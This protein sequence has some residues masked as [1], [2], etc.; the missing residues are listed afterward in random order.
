[1]EKEGNSIIEVSTL[2]KRFGNLTAVNQISFSVS[3]GE[4]FGFLGPNGAG[5]TTT[6]RTLTGLLT[7]DSG[8]IFVDGHDIKKNLIKAKMKMGVIPE[9]GNVYVDLT[10]KQN[11][12]LAG[13]FYGISTKELEKR[14]DYLLDEFGLYE[15]KDDIVKTFSKGMKQ[16]VNIASAI[17]HN[18]DILFLDEPTMGLDVQSQRL[19][20][21]I[22]KDMNQR[23]TTIFL[24]THNIEEANIQCQRVG[25][26]NKGTIAAID[27]PENL[28]RIFEQAQSVEISFNKPINIALIKNSQLVEK[29]E[30]IGDKWK[31]YTDDPDGLVKYL[32]K[33]AQEQNL[34]LTSMQICG[35]SLEDVFVKLTEGRDYGN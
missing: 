9:T 33:F 4:I 7:P 31:L 16:R 35:A 15:R 18:P 10:A 17:V 24:T 22:I 29:I 30:Q 34:I 32:A 6:I 14:A 20:R 26:I 28:K 5:K 1:M 25:I 2:T 23:G 12:I 21:K 13:K 19:I 3:K 11:M 27:S 8:N